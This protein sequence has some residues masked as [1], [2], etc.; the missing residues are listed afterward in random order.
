MFMKNLSSQPLVSVVIPCY[1]HEKFVQD[2]IKSVIAQTYENI[3]LIII[4]DGS[5]DGSVEKIKEMVDICE[6]RFVRFEFRHRA[7]IGLSATLNEAL[8]W[9]EGKYYSAIASDDI[10]LKDK[11]RTQVEFLEQNI[12]FVGVF[13]NAQEINKENEY[14]NNISVKSRIFTFEKILLH[15]EN[16][17]APT[18]MLRLK[19]LIKSGGYN[20]KIILED[21][22]TWLSIS[23]YGNIYSLDKKLCLYRRHEN[24]ISNNLEVMHKGRLQV[25]NYFKEKNINPHVY[26]K[27][28]KRIRWINACDIF[29][30]KKRSRFIS[31]SR[32]LLADTP[33]TIKVIYTEVSNSLNSKQ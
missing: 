28:L 18:Q 5:K 17:L 3:E 9:C 20:D 1:N 29:V 24:N 23:R 16:L 12:N 27:A 14:L 8:E 30:N 19:T 31:F 21:W 10:M 6:Q 26:K 15:E 32:M 22:Y 2:S 13:G 11:T 25:L 33:K 7:N 4:D